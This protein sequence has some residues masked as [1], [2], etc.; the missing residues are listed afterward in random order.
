MD[1]RVGVIIIAI[2]EIMSGYATLGAG[3]TWNTVIIAIS[4]VVAGKF[5][6]YG[7]IT[8]SQT[9]TIVN[10]V[11]SGIGI[12]FYAIASIIS[13]IAVATIDP[14]NPNF[15]EVAAK[16]IGFGTLWLVLAL[17]NLYFCLCVYSFLRG[18][19][20]GSL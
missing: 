3:V 16:D 9:A 5:L 11:V 7:T 13:L 18:L 4:F 17:L 14:N 2:F 6:L 12:I 10:L 19:K 1:L 15:Y 20:S 8:Y